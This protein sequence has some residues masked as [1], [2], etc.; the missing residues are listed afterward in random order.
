MLKYLKITVCKEFAIVVFLNKILFIVLCAGWQQAATAAVSKMILPSSLV[1][2]QKPKTAIK[3][4]RKAKLESAYYFKVKYLKITVCKEFAIVV[5]L[6]K[7]L[8]I[9]LC[10]GWQQAATAAVSKMILPSSLVRS[11]KPRTTIY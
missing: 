11:R 10:A 7:I 4:D 5:F 9:V 6:N 1:W 3:K 8:F 2:S